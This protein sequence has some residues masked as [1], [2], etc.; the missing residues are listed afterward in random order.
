MKDKEVHGLLKLPDKVIVKNLQAELDKANSL[1]DE[2]N[3]KISSMRQDREMQSIESLR[4]TIKSLNKQIK[5]NAY[6]AKYQEAKKEVKKLR[7]ENSRLLTKL[8]QCRNNL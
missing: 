2:L 5:E 1:I 6:Y 4:G 8:I 7:E 3:Y